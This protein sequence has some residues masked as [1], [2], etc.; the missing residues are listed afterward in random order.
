VTTDGFVDTDENGV[1]ING[2]RFVDH[3]EGECPLLCS[4]PETGSVSLNVGRKYDILKARL[5]IDDNS[6]SQ[7]KSAAIEIIA[8]GD[9]I[10]HGSFRLG[11]S[12]DISL[13]ISNVL[14]LT[15]RFSGPLGYVHPAVGDPTAYS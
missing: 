13:N 3:F 4:D 10:F 11:I 7:A 5:G 1:S 9:I 15:F 12:K 14:R 2:K 8:D 6:P